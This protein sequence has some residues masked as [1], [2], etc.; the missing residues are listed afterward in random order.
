[1]T[2]EEAFKKLAELNVIKVKL[3][4]ELKEVYQE[5]IAVKQSVD[6]HLEGLC[7]RDETFYYKIIVDTGCHISY[8]VCSSPERRPKDSQIY[9]VSDYDKMLF[10]LEER[11]VITIEEFNKTLENNY[12]RIK[13]W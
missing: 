9:I 7:F 13:E 6:K 1:M 5:I 4:K 10:L 3:D 2:K 8:I 12:L 11:E